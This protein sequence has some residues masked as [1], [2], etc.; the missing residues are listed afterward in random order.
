MFFRMKFDKEMK[1]V[2][3][4]MI[5]GKDFFLLDVREYEEYEEGHLPGAICIPLQTVKQQIDA[6][7]NDKPVYV[8]CRSGQR[9]NACVNFLKDK[10]R[11]NV[12][13]I[14]GIIYWEYEIE[15]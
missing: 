14:G 1:E 2:H 11:R 15:K 9:S 3:Q 13:N 8:Y 6:I 5:E 4:E 10:G 7:P 12:Y